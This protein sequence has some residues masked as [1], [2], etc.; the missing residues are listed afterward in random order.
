MLRADVLQRR[1]QVQQQI[2]PLRCGM[3]TKGRATATATASTTTDSSASLRND[4]KR[5]GNDKCND[6]YD[7][8]GE[9]KY[10][11]RFLR[12]AAE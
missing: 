12:F 1:I 7:C 3:T 5:A 8:N 6:Y 10:N 4:N 11:S 2:P 9:C